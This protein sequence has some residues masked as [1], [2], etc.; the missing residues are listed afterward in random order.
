MTPKA[1]GSHEQSKNTLLQNEQWHKAILQASM[2]G[3][4]MTD[5][6]GRLLEVNAAYCR[7]SGYSEQE[8]LT[9]CIADLE[10]A[11]TRDDVTRHIQSLMAQGEMRFETR[12]RRRDGTVYDVEV[13]IQYRSD[14]GGRVVSFLR[15]ITERKQ[16]ETRLAERNQFIESIID[17]TPDILYIYDIIEKRN[18]YSNDGI[19][20]ILGYTVEEIQK[21]GERII[22]LLMHPDDFNE[23]LQ[24]TVPRYATA[25]D[26][27]QVIHQYRMKHKNGEWRWLISNE[28]I[29][30]RH[31]D[32]TPKQIF[33]MMHDI[34]ESE[35][36][37]EALIQN[38]IK[39][40]SLFESIGQGFYLAEIIY[41]T[42]G[43]PC[44]FK[45]IE[46]N[47]E[48]EHMMGLSKEQIIG[49]T[50]NE[51]VPPDPESGWPDCFKRV[52]TTGMPENYTFYSNVYNKY[53]EVYAFRPDEGKFCALV[54]DITEI[55]RADEKL[56]ESE[57]RF[58]KIFEETTLGIVTVLPSF[59]FEKVN[60]AFCRMLGY[61]E[62]ELKTMKFMDITHPDYIGHDIEY[63]KKVR[64]GE[65]PFYQVEKRYIQK[66]GKVIWGN[67]IVS[68][69]RDKQGAFLYFLCMINDI[70]EHIQAEEAL[71]KSEALLKTQFDNSPDIIM[72]LDRE[73]R[74][75]SINKII[76]TQYTLE[77]LIGMDAV[78]I[79][80]EKVRSQVNDRLHECFKTGV[81][82]QFE[83]PVVNEKWAQARIIPLTTGSVIDQVMIISTDITERKQAE[84]LLQ[85]KTEEIKARNKELAQSNKELLIAKE[86][87]EYNEKLLKNITDNIPAYIAE[88][89][90]TTLKYKFVNSKFTTGFNK[91]YEEILGSH[92][93]EII[94]KSNTEYAMKYIDEVRNGN[95]SSYINTFDLTEG[96]RYINVHYVPGFDENGKVENII[97]LSTDI[98]AIKESEQEL[99]K[100]KEHAEESEEKYRALYNSMSDAL[101]ITELNDDGTLSN[102]T[103]VNDI[104]CE[105]LGY[106]REELLSK[107]PADINSENTRLHLGA[108]VHK[109]LNEKIKIV[110]HEHVTKDGRIIPV[111]ISSNFIRHKDKIIF[112]A[113]A[114]DI[115]ERKKAE[116]EKAELESRLQQAQKLESIGRLAGG[117][118]HDFNNMLGV[119]LGNVEMA[120]TQVEPA[121]PLY[122]DLIE[123]R[124]AAERSAD[125]TRQ[126][127]AFARK[128]TIAPKVLDLNSTVTGMLKMLTRLISEN[129]HL[130]WQPGD[131]LW[132]VKMDPTQ[133]D[134]ILVNL[135]V[136]ARNAI[137]DVGE[138][139]IIT[140]NIA[141]DA[142]SCAGL[143]DAIPGEYVRITVADNGRGMDRETLAR[144]F[145]PFFTTKSMGAGTG[146][147]L[148]TV[149]GAVKQNNG[150]IHAES[151]PG[152]GTAFEIYL[153]RSLSKVEQAARSE[154]TSMTVGRSCETI[155]LVED[156]TA[157]LSLI[158][159][160]LKSKGYTVLTAESPGAAIQLAREH[161]GEIH[162]LL[163]DVIMPEMNGRDLA[164]NLLSLYPG[165]KR[166]FMSGYTADVIAHHGVLEPGVFFIQKPLTQKE[167]LDKI[168]EVLEH[169]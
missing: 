157:L 18:I 120:L 111:E 154:S 135:C 122:S 131:D 116:S 152:K 140:E 12:H 114:R 77:E 142:E 52:A 149:Y 44:D 19:Q 158:S 71:I 46:V 145:E 100:A 22:P 14:E 151:T 75:V 28:T 35:L 134:Q 115:T 6:Q 62:D 103:M 72:V 105:S 113:I 86:K 133:L 123:I 166:L 119:I 48:F 84:L 70:T 112:N 138:V 101:F 24:K 60:P 143:P 148:A 127:L 53:Y 66:S 153:P 27:E 40:R 68:C 137:T 25:R 4:V 7:M 78:E 117:V 118:A 67:I 82:Q 26:K 55:K 15:D 23:Y 56:R 3:F 59:I 161:A 144:I 58:R 47:P 155:L 97:L 76:F 61:T 91:K 90:A 34:T 96:K 98:T 93:S 110:E 11:E 168:Q 45:Y 49:K 10:A 51:F 159:R 64:D 89:D 107:S 124:K 83:H 31:K 54:K 74:I 63:V 80:P 109:I 38:E 37:K 17:N 104:A 73:F 21:M 29:Y 33:G 16:A 65:I 167:L 81:I 163:T 9:M 156:E 126:L 95:P 87:A 136:N 41:D 92:I 106:T 50:Y 2:D 164:K 147:G 36:A 94:G 146:L 69:I 20:K 125:L 32:G 5:A 108:S 129:V 165:L 141:L 169:T 139:S 88:V 39:F 102:F 1:G 79:L 13:S 99:Q 57:E 42:D 150:F 128:Q 160:I 162:L 85:A 43:I 130:N 30:L 121:Q 8:L 132:P